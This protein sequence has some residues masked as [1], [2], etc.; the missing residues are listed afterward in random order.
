M[1]ESVGAHA[2]THNRLVKIKK[3]L[4]CF[5]YIIS[6]LGIPSSYEKFTLVR[7]VG[8]AFSFDAGMRHPLQAGLP[9]FLQV[10]YGKV[11]AA[12]FMGWVQKNLPHQKK[13]TH[14]RGGRKSSAHAFRFCNQKVV[15]QYV[16]DPC[17]SS[18]GAHADRP[19]PDGTKER[20]GFDQIR[21]L[22]CL[23]CARQGC[24]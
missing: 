7:P 4:V 8:N 1:N 15:L 19:F 22:P 11:R 5:P 6:L 17:T 10:C 18:A 12:L 24:V 14:P 23:F 20:I 9:R 3:E 13:R 16:L 21:Q 2:R